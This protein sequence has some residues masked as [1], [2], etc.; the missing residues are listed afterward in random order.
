MA[1][2][3]G[4]GWLFG[5]GTAPSGF[6]FPGLGRL[7]GSGAASSGFS[8]LGLGLL[9]GSGGAPSGL[10]FPGLG[11]LS[12]WGVGCCLAG[13][14]SAGLVFQCFCGYFWGRGCS[15]ARGG[16]DC[17]AEVNGIWRKMSCLLPE[18]SRK[19][20]LFATTEH[21]EHISSLQHHL[22]HNRCVRKARFTVRDCVSRPF[23]GDSQPPLFHSQAARLAQI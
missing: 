11:W 9:S 12:G 17:L 8:F 15:M 20:G 22:A 1:A 19:P 18:S 5:S 7:S 6:S 4:C 2:W 23:A 10:S 21:A 16:R 13:V 3:L 14:R